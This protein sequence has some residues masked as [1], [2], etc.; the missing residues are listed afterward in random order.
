MLCSLTKHHFSVV[1][2]PLPW[3]TEQGVAMVRVLWQLNLL[4]L[5]VPEA[6]IQ[7]G[8]EIT[9][10]TAISSPPCHI[11]QNAADVAYSECVVFHDMPA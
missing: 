9:V 5:T 7:V 11:G 3:S 6:I 4:V 10:D 8:L 2:S 1:Q